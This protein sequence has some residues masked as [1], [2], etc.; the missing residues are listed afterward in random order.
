MATPPVEFGTIMDPVNG[1]IQLD[2]YLFKIIDR[3]EF[4]RLRKIKQL[5]G[6]CYVYPGATHTRF[7]HSI[8]VCYIASQL[9]D[10][11]NKNQQNIITPNEKKCI[12]IAALCHDLGHGPY[13]HLYDFA[14]KRHLEKEN[15]EKL[16]KNERKHEYRSAEL[17]QDVMVVVKKEFFP[18]NAADQKQ[19]N[20]WKQYIKL[21]QNMIKFS[22]I[23]KVS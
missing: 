13:S 14:V 23:F 2:K 8:G 10:A 9:V 12:Q 17:I 19:E 22:E 3:P 5:G 6:V 20:T 21:V 1:S 7:E 11:L 15:P 16:K 18:K 4:Q